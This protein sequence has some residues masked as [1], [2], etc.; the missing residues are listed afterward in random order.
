MTPTTT[1]RLAEKE[2]PEN[3]EG[4]HWAGSLVE[5]ERQMRVTRGY[6]GLIISCPG[7]TK[8]KHPCR[9][10]CPVLPPPLSTATFNLSLQRSH[11]WIL[12]HS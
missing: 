8:P 5:N 4:G 11:C 1:W 7:S 10:S 6:L 12:F 3:E 9:W 2:E